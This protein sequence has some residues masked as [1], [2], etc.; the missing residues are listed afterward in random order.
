MEL[1][2]INLTGCRAEASS[3]F[4]HANWLPIQNGDLEGLLNPETAFIYPQSSE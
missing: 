4:L 2:W 1:N 3:S